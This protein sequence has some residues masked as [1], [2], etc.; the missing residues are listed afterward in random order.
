MKDFREIKTHSG[1]DLDYNS[2]EGNLSMN[3]ETYICILCHCLGNSMLKI[4]NGNLLQ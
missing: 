2:N 4:R 3:Q 1:I